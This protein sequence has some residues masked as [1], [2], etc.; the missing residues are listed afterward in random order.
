MLAGADVG[1]VTKE[2]E[3]AFLLA[4]KQG[5]TAVAQCLHKHG[6]AIVRGGDL[7]W[8]GEFMDRTFCYFLIIF[9][10]YEFFVLHRH[11]TTQPGPRGR[12]WSHAPHVGSQARPSV[13]CPVPRPQWSACCH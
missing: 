7:S 11:T 2:G 1:V 9:L 10:F 3:D 12:V 4:C 13:H 6:A 5:H 8:S